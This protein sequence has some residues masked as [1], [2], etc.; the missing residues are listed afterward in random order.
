[1]QLVGV[2]TL[3]VQ[4]AHVFQVTPPPLFYPIIVIIIPHS[5]QATLT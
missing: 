1:M 2:H 3:T 5:H 4:G